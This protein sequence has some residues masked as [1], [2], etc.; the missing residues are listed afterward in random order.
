MDSLKDRLLSHYGLSKED[1]A[2]FTAEPSFSLIPTI[3]E[4]PSVKEAIRILNASIKAKQRILIYGDYDTDGIMATSIIKRALAH[5]DV[6]ASHFIP[7]RYVDGYGL[8]LD[9]AKKIA[10]AGYGLVI[11]VDNGVSCF[12]SVSFLRSEAINVLIIDH[13]DLPASL[14][15]AN[16]IIHDKLLKNGEYPVSAGFLSYLFSRALLSRHDSYLFVLGALSLISDVMPVLG[17]NRAAIGL[18]LREIREREF[19]EIMMLTERK[20]YIDEKVLSGEIIPK[21][22]AVGRIELNHAGNRLVDYF[23]T[24]EAKGKFDTAAYMNEVNARRKLLTVEAA[25]QVETKEEEPGI[26]VKLDALEGLNGLIANRLLTEYKKPVVV[27]SSSKAEKS[28]LVGSFRAKQGFEF[29]AFRPLVERLLIRYGGHAYAAGMSIKEEDFEEFKSVFLAYAKDHPL[30][31][32]IPETIPLYLSEVHM[33]T[34]REIRKFGP[35]GEKHKEPRF[36]IEGVPSGSLRY[37]KEGKYMKTPLP[38]SKKTSLLS[39]SFGEKD[40]TESEVTLEGVF[41]I[42]EF[43]GDI[44]LNLIV[45]KI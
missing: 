7:S 9:N 14:P 25:G 27:F 12:E 2:V 24:F 37:F 4:E 10:K 8:T 18:A 17:Q 32:P 38:D 39:F 23:A 45:E 41:Q 16:A 34:Y 43:N 30:T 19:P 40:I 29:P 22:N 44:G 31:E 11:L 36:R 15:P 20:R 13:H 33:G 26:C 5:L 42:S 35:F 3:E 1:Y 28:V 6:D 21:I